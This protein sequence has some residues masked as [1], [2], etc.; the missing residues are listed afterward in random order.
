MLS[1]LFSCGCLNR[2]FA[3]I[4]GSVIGA[5]VGEGGSILV[6]VVVAIIVAAGALQAASSVRRANK[7]TIAA[8]SLIVALCP[9]F[10]TMRPPRSEALCVARHQSSRHYPQGHDVVPLRV[11]ESRPLAA[12]LCSR[13][14]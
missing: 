12:L 13:R 1:V 9:R 14:L 3:S 4:L 5:G 7:Q 11:V 2:E 10:S 6:G 8:A